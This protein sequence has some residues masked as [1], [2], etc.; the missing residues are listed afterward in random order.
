MSSAW[1]VTQE[2]KKCFKFQAMFAGTNAVNV[3][4]DV[5]L[6][7]TPLHPIWGLKLP[8]RKKI[9]VSGIL[10]LGTRQALPSD[11]LEFVSRC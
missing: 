4:M 5:V 6:L 1:G 10:I 7:I 2:G 3:I 11:N 8:I 9:L